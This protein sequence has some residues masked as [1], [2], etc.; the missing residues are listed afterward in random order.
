MN[1]L[2]G[3]WFKLV[4]ERLTHIGLL[5]VPENVAKAFEKD[6]RSHVEHYREPSLPM[7]NWTMAMM[8][9]APMIHKF[10]IGQTWD[11]EGRD[12]LRLYMITPDEIATEPGF[13]FLP[14]AEYLRRPEKAPEREVVS[15][16]RHLA[17]A[18]EVAG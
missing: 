14:S 11:R 2:S 10:V 18:R 15:P 9:T 4:D 5:M 16:G 17:A 12:A 6:K 7:G 8:A 13:V 1:R 3:A